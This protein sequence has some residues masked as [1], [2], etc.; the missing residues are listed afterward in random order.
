VFPAAINCVSPCVSEK[1]IGAW[2]AGA[3]NCAAT[4][5]T[6][7]T[8]GQFAAWNARKRESGRSRMM[9]EPQAYFVSTVGDF[10]R[11]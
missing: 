11:R 8:S 6:E 1:P 10:F 4:A 9:P 2:G 3:V 5:M 7:T